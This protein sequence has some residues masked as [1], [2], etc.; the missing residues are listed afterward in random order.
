[1]EQ[2]G[3]PA[4]RFGLAFDLRSGRVIAAGGRGLGMAVVRG[5]GALALG[6]GWDFGATT[7]GF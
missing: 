3:R 5:D 4:V 7:D 1:V 6:A 2:D